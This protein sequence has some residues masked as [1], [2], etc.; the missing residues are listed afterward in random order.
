MMLTVKYPTRSRPEIA[1]RTLS[2]YLADPLAKVIVGID[3]DDESMCNKDMLAWL[4]QQPRTQVHVGDSTS[5]VQAVNAGL[6]EIEWD[7]VLVVA[8]DDM[9]P[10]R[11][12]YARRILELYDEFFPEGDGVLHLDDGRVGSRLNTICICD[13]VYYKRFG[14]LYRPPDKGGYSSL[15]CDNEWQEVSER[16]GKSIYVNEC[17][18]RHDW[19]ETFTPTICT[20]ATSPTTT[21]TPLRSDAARPQGFPS[22]GLIDVNSNREAQ[23]RRARDGRDGNDP[24]HADHDARNQQGPHAGVRHHG[25]QGEPRLLRGPHDRRQRHPAEPRFRRRVT[26]R[27]QR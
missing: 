14:Y 6:D 5:K 7:G 2:M 25:E 22:K 24:R 20:G 1:M 13:S 4:M 11:A 18:L 10:Q 3:R 12:D 27:H 17:L 19:V 16:L 15:W 26:A 21:P 8:S 23:H 9:I